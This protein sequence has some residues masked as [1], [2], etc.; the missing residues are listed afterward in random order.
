MKIRQI[1]N[2]TILLDYGAQKILVDPML[3]KAG[4]IP[5]L[6]WITMKRRRNPLVELPAEIDPILDSVTHILI[7]HCQKGHFDHLDRAAISWIRRKK[8]PVFC[9]L[10]DAEYLRKLKL[11]VTPLSADSANPFFEG[12]ISLVPCR[13]GLGLVGQLMAHGFGYIIKRPQHPSVYV[14]GD[15]IFTKEIQSA[16]R[17]NQPDIV[18]MPGGGA[19]FDIGGDIIMSDKDVTSVAECF[20]G[21]LLVNHLEALDHCPTTREQIKNLAKTQSLSQ[22]VQAPEDGEE[23]EFQENGL[24]FRRKCGVDCIEIT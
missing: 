16:L 14:I 5:S 12:E 1:R 15:S 6:K 23:L 22:R 24:L 2:A 18:I 13:H 10:E 11:E 4:T 8:I 19:Q 7:T 3:A 17:N 20:L 21:Q 9:A